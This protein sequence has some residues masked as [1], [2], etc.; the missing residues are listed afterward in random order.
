MKIHPRKSLVIG[1]AV[2]LAIACAASA[3]A[4][5]HDEAESA[6]KGVQLPGVVAGATTVVTAT[7]KAVDKATRKVAFEGPEGNQVVVT[8]GPEVKNFEQIAVGDKLVIEYT[9]AVAAA[10]DPVGKASAAGAEAAL[11]TAPLGAKPAMVATETVEIRAKILAVDKEKR[12]LT[13]E[14]PGGNKRTFRVGKEVERFDA[15]EPGQDV[16]VRYTESVAIKITPP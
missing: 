14:G 12:K 9:E 5:Q 3:T 4:A 13:V 7:V 15:L 16:V 6:P 8:A 2:A 11:E 1:Q 10:V